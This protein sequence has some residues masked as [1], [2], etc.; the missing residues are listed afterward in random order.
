MERPPLPLRCKSSEVGKMDMGEPTVAVTDMNT[1]EGGNVSMKTP[2]RLMCDGEEMCLLVEGLA[3]MSV[4]SEEFYCLF[5]F[6]SFRCIS[7]V[8]T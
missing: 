3:I 6:L 1:W 8:L 2:A 5:V 7:R 4:D